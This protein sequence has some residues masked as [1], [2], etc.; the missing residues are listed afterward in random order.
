[1]RTIGLELRGTIAAEDQVAATYE[2][3]RV[4]FYSG[5]RVFW[6]PDSIHE[7]V[8]AMLSFA[9]QMNARWLIADFPAAE[10]PP[11]RR[12]PG[13]SL[14]RSFPHGDREVRVFRDSK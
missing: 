12:L 11:A 10:A 7:D 3:F 13:W 4:G 8:P 2:T 14:A 6:V 9:G 5:G 1:M